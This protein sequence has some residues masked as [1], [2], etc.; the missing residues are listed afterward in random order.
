MSEPPDISPYRKEFLERLDVKQDMRKYREYISASGHADFEHAPAA[1]HEIIVDACQRLLDPNHPSKRL[2]IMA[3]PGSA[4]STY[5]SV[6]FAT[7]F[8]AQNPWMTILCCSNTTD[9]ARRFNRRRKSVIE[10]EEWQK[11]SGSSLDP[12]NTSVDEWGTLAGGL[13]IAKGVGSTITGTRSDLNILDDPISSFEEANSDTQ[14]AQQIDWYEADYR[15]RLKPNGLELMIMTRWAAKDLAGVMIERNKRGDEDWEI[16]RLPM[17]ADVPDD[18][19]GRALGE[20][21]W[22]E[23]FTPHQLRMAKKS[24]VKWQAMYQQTPSNESGSW[25]S[26]DQIPIVHEGLVPKNLRILIAMD[27]AMGVRKGDYTVFIV[28]GLSESRDLYV[29]DVLRERCSIEETTSTLLGLNRR[30]KPY[31]VLIDNDTSAQMFASFVTPRVRQEGTSIPIKALP[32]GNRDKE[33]RASNIRAYFREGK[34]FLKDA[35]WN[36]VLIDE[37]LEFPGGGH[38]DQIDC[39]SL[40][41]RQMGAISAPTPPPTKINTAPV[42]AL[43]ETEHG[44]ETRSTFDE[45]FEDNKGSRGLRLANRRRI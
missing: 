36:E 20:P 45:L 17:E 41:G 18:P 13:V 10:T 9:L 40:L 19:L 27:L 2:L 25:V 22:P 26:K 4:K 35:A 42:T 30:L 5:S 31:Q 44:L 1:H 16:V 34:V 15:T 23:W 38:D 14:L 39:L 12:T 8:L 7:W 6:Q 11:L 24:E 21:L 33:D 29:L 3:P 37:M 28:A 43:V 32:H